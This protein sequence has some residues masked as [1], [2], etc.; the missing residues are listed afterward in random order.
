MGTMR[1][2]R[3]VLQQHSSN[4]TGDGRC[5]GNLMGVPGSM[6]ILE[7]A[8]W[9]ARHCVEGI[10]SSGPKVPSEHVVGAR[11]PLPTNAVKC[12]RRR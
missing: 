3:N 4:G 12:G 6:K 11:V 9:W 1:S 2:D 7:F 10:R 8:V 5:D